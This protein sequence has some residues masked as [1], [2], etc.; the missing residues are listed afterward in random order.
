MMTAISIWVIEEIGSAR[1]RMKFIPYHLN[2]L[3]QDYT[4]SQTR[5]P[6]N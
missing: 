6:Y 3:F 4:Q 2:S 5:F 1:L